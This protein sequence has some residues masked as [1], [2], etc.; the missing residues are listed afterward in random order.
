[1]SRYY[2]RLDDAAPQWNRDNWHYIE[3][4]LS[5]YKIKPLIGLIPNCKD[6]KMNHL[7]DD[8]FWD[9]MKIWHAKGYEL[10]LHG[11]DHVYITKESGINPVNCKSEFAGVDLD[12]Q[13]YKIRQGINILSEHGIHPRVF[14]APSHTYDINTLKALEMESKIRI[15]SDTFA[16][17]PYKFNN[18]IFIPVQS[19]RCRYLP[20]STI[21]YCL[22]PNSMND[23]QFKEL[24]R[25]IK[26][27]YQN[28]ENYNLL[29]DQ[30]KINSSMSIIDKICS[31][32]YY[33]YRKLIMH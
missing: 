13:C 5:K 22:H 20:F 23:N 28:F 1:M 2:I 14:F 21:T 10:A 32:L 7:I 27:N 18:F 9:T 25:F 30:I 31:C 24:E 8:S 17:K 12:I 26:S 33:K 19:G 15:I 16:S 6:P 4:I 11:Y 3:Q 29:I